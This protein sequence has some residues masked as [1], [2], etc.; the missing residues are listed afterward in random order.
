ML[1][2]LGNND[3]KSLHMPSIGD[4]FKNYFPHECADVEPA[5]MKTQ[6]FFDIKRTAI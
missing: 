2:W 1:G 3:K 6:L 5:A 4:C